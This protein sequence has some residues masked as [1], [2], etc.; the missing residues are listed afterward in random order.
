M[1]MFLKK[2]LGS[3][4]FMV[5]LGAFVVTLGVITWGWDETA[6]VE[7]SDKI[8]NAVLLLASLYIGGTALEDA[9]AKI[10]GNGG[11]S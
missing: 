9:A 11:S 7:M 3:R 5:A 10:K 6:A 4:K 8:I 1:K 2:Y